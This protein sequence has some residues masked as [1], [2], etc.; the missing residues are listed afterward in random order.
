MND[1]FIGIPVLHQSFQNGLRP[2]LF[3]INGSGYAEGFI[4]IDA[5]HAMASQRRL[6]YAAKHLLYFVCRTARNIRWIKKTI[7]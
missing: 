2:E 6:V 3:F 1:H 7:F 5:Q 4:F